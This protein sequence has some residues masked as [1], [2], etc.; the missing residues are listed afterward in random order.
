MGRLNLVD[1]DL[2]TGY[3]FEVFSSNEMETLV[4]AGCTSLGVGVLLVGDVAR[5]CQIP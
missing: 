2:Q 1:A 4:K 3:R 5:S